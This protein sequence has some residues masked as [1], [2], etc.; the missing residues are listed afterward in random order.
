MELVARDAVQDRAAQAARLGEARARLVL[1]HAAHSTCS[2]KVRLCMA[3]KGLAY[4][5]RVLEVR[6]NE[7]LSD[8]YLAINPN[9]VVPTLT[10]DGAPVRDSS[11]I[12]EYLDEAFPAPPLS[13]S[14]PL[15]RADMRAWLRYL[16]EVPTVAIRIPS[17]NAIFLPLI[18]QLGAQWEEVKRK[19]PLRK[20]LYERIGEAGFDAGEVRH[21]MEQ[22][23]GS[24]E[25]A[26][27]AIANQGWLSGEGL[28]LADLVFLPTVVRLDDLGH[29]AMWTH[30]PAVTQW[31]AALRARPSFDIAFFPGSRLTTG[32]PERVF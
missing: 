31:Y 7:H 30:L 6:K 24:L 12:C 5:S 8:E 29:S 27:R 20:Q 9:G 26:E 22:L 15:G 4:E 11:V 28:T 32:D 14:T 21:S 17:I 18:H 25:R 19:T 16:E 23:T 13:P 1:F 2:Q 10:H 3:E